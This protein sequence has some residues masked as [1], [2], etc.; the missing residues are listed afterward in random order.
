RPIASGGGDNRNAMPHG[1]DSEPWRDRYAHPTA[2]DQ[3][4]EPLAMTDLFAASVAACPDSPLADFYGRIYTYR[5]MMEEA[6]AFAAG[7]Q[8]MGIAKGDRVGLFLPNVPV[9]IP[10]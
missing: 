4:F 9:Y 10:A 8:A 6:R 1:R 3:Q 7:L 5:A 2:W